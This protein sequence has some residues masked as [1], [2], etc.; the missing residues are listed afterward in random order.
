[1]DPSQVQD[2]SAWTLADR[3]AT[4]QIDII[5]CHDVTHDIIKIPCAAV[6]CSQLVGQNELVDQPHYVKVVHSKWTIALDP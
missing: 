5:Q 1:M 3:E 2:T 4:N 6:E